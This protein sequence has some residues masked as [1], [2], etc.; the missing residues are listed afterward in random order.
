HESGLNVH[1]VL[2]DYDTR[3]RFK[4]QK[5]PTS[6]IPAVIPRQA[7]WKRI[8]GLGGRVK[9]DDRLLANASLARSYNGANSRILGNELVQGY[10][11]FEED[12]VTASKEASICEGRKARWLVVYAVCQI[13]RKVTE[14]PEEVI[15]AEGIDY[16]VAISTEGLPPW[17]KAGAEAG[18]KGAGVQGKPLEAA[19]PAGPTLGPTHLSQSRLGNS[20]SHKSTKSLSR[21]PSS[22]TAHRALS[23]SIKSLSISTPA[24]R[25]RHLAALSGSSQSSGSSRGFDMIASPHDTV[26]TE[27]TPSLRDSIKTA[28]STDASTPPASPVPRPPSDIPAR[29]AR[30]NVSMMPAPAHMPIPSVLSTPMMRNR[31]GRPLSEEFSGSEPGYAVGYAALAEEERDAVYG[32][33]DGV[34]WI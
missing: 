11:R 17:D 32:S 27:Y 6:L 16:H 28:S 21:K 29:K 8:S 10:R 26:P 13:L 9:P 12:V 15:D 20:T 33:R 30:R 19:S 2:K 22:H 14:A 31:G 5:H 23:S 24:R 34:S 1:R 7:T 25:L 4:S 3:R 18:S